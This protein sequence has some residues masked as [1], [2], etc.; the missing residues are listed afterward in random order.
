[1]RLQ[2]KKEI[3]T[4]YINICSLCIFIIYNMIVYHNNMYD[5]TFNVYIFINYLKNDSI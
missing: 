3:F 4:L 2:R 1:M 5:V